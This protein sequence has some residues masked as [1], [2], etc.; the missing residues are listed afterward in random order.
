[1]KKY[2]YMILNCRRIFHIIQ[3]ILNEKI[4]LNEVFLAP[5]GAQ[6][7]KMCVRPSVRLCVRDIMLKR[8][9]KGVIQGI[10][11]GVIQGNLRGNLRGNIRGNLRGN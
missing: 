1:M 4:I 6:G 7:V 8:V 9:P 11:Q 5:T 10:I 3:I 2:H